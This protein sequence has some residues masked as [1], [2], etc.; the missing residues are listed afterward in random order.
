MNEPRTDRL[1]YRVD[2]S[3]LA[4]EIAP[5]RSAGDDPMN[6]RQVFTSADLVGRLAKEHDRIARLS[7]ERAR[8]VVDGTG[9]IVTERLATLAFSQLDRLIVRARTLLAT[10]GAMVRTFLRG[11][12]DLEWLDPQ[13]GTVTFPRIRG[14]A[15]TTR[16]A[17]RLLQQRGVAQVAVVAGENDRLG[18]GPDAE[19][20]EDIRRVIA[21][22][23]FADRQLASD[24][25]IPQTFGDQREYLAFPPGEPCEGRIFAAQL[26]SPETKEA[27]AGRFFRGDGS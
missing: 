6:A 11:R 8:D 19:L 24:L 20:V 2:E 3:A 23:L 12:H 13:G 26:R 5:R 17:E 7:E 22:R 9:P 16:F 14:V 25:R 18:A 4:L 21:D 1:E 27:L 10:N 15:D